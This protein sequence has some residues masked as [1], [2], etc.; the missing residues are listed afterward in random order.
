MLYPFLK[1]SGGR[2]VWTGSRAASRSALKVP[3]LPVPILSHDPYASA[4]CAQD[5]LSVSCP[6]CFPAEIVAVF[7]GEL[8][9]S[10]FAIDQKCRSDG[11][12]S[13]VICPGFVDTDVAPGFFRI[14][15]GI[16]VM[17]RYVPMSSP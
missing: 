8:L 9:L 4:K 14:F 3:G 15:R 5:L 1:K 16:L 10:Q 12:R 6:L 13:A 11:V 17:M 2:I 7:V